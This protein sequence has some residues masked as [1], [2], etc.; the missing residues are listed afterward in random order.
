MRSRKLRA[1]N[2]SRRVPD[3]VVAQLSIE[4]LEAR[5]LPS[6]SSLAGALL[7]IEPNETIDQAHDL[8]GLNPVT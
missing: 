7:Q 4:L 3:R 8:G 6:A 2:S 1:I 5:W